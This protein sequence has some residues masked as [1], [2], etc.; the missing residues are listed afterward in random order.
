MRLF[1]RRGPRALPASVAILFF[2][3]LSLGLLAE[4]ALAC[5]APRSGTDE[6]QAAPAPTPCADQPFAE[7]DTEGLPRL[8][9]EVAK[10][11]QERERGLMFRESM[12]ENQGM[13]FVFQPQS[14]AGFWMRNT[15]IPLSLAWL[16]AGGVIV[17]IQD[18]QPLTE[19]VHMP[20]A[21]YSYAIEANRGWFQA[22]GV[23]PGQHVRLCLG[24]G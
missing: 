20:A 24:N 10:T 12:P 19:T 7:V 1:Q 2:V 17:D 11:D 6:P 3:V 4:S 23:V 18:M 16:D 22:S 8:N 15:L 14:R 21:P 9:L 5:T 13:L